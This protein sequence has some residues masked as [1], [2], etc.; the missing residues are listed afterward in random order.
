LKKWIEA[1][2]TIEAGFPRA[3]PGRIAKILRQYVYTL[4]D[5]KSVHGG[6][7]SKIVCIGHEPLIILVKKKN[8]SQKFKFPLGIFYDS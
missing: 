1:V 5:E 7:M 2:T 3:G 6:A 8:L 4:F